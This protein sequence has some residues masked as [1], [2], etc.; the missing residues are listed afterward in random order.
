MILASMYFQVISGKHLAEI[1]M[2]YNLLEVVFHN[3]FDAQDQ[4]DHP[5]RTFMYLHLFSHE[6]A[7]ELTTEHLV[8]EGAVFNQI[9]ATTHNSLINHLNDTYTSF[10]YGEDENFEERLAIMKMDNGKTLPKA[11]INWEM[12]YVAIWRK[13]T[14]ALMDIIYKNDEEVQNDKYLQDVHRGLKE[15]IFRDLPARYDNFQTKAGVSR[16]ASDTIHHLVVRHQVYGTTGINAAMDPRISTTQV[17]K[18]QGT[19]GVDEWRSLVCVGLA[20]ACARFTLLVGEDGETYTYLLD[21]VSEEYKD[22]MAKVFVQLQEDLLALDRLWTS[23]N[24][25]MEY[26]YNYFRAVPSDLRTGPGY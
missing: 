12:E 11:C 9:F 17:P 2:T 19:Q 16:W 26:N 6:L 1:H 10:E 22:P 24:I 21:G 3:A 15:V 4:F 5:F 8:Q 18:D 23:D 7:E 20:T 25:H 14:D 13:Y